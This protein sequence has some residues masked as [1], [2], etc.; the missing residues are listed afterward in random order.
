VVGIALV[1][2]WL[3]AVIFAPLLGMAILKAPNGANA[4]QAPAPGR[5]LQG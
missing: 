1:V 2:S 4:G 5:I 3:V